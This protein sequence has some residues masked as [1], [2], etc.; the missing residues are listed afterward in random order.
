MSRCFAWTLLTEESPWGPS[1]CCHPDVTV[2]TLEEVPAY[3]RHLEAPRPLHDENVGSRSCHGRNSLGSWPPPEPSP[4]ESHS[5]TWAVKTDLSACFWLLTSLCS[6]AV[7]CPNVRNDEPV[8]P[9]ETRQPY[10]YQ[11]YSE[12]KSSSTWLNTRR[13]EL[14]PLCFSKNN[15]N[16]VEKIFF[17]WVTC[18]LVFSSCY[19]MD[20]IS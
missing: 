15:N 16:H 10:I 9:G 8:H 20:H 1:A 13:H 14:E 18:L 2:M 7:A 11:K 5:H 3:P 6:V 17:T 12:Q 4:R 19:L